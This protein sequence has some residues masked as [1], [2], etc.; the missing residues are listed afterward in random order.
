MASKFKKLF[1]AP[2]LL[3][4][5]SG[6]FIAACVTGLTIYW[7]VV[8]KLPAIE[9]LRD[10]Q[11]QVPLKIYTKDEKLIAEYGEKRRAPLEI[12]Q[13]PK[14]LINAVLSAED[15]RFY[16]H[17]GVDPKGLLRA[18][19]YLIR[20]GH[21][22]PGGS[23]ITM[24]VARNFFL[25]RE[26]TY[27]RKLNE[28]LLSF[29]IEQ[30]LSKDE[31]LELYLNKIYLGNR[32]YGF[33]AAAQVYY[34]KTLDEMTPA[35]IAM[36]AGLPKAPSAYNP[37]VNPERALKRRNYVLSRMNDLGFLSDEDYETARNSVDDAELHGLRVEVEAPYLAEMVRAEL[38]DR[39]GEDTYTQGYKV[40]TTVESRTQIAANEA[41]RKN[42]IAYEERHGFRGP[43]ANVDL[44][45]VEGFDEMAYRAILSDYRPVNKL[46]A[47]LVTAVNEKDIVV[48]QSRHGQIKIDWE[49]LKWARPW[50][51]DGKVPGEEPTKASDFLTTG[52]IIRIVKV[53]DGKEGEPDVWKLAQIP[54][55]EGA[56]VSLSA[57]DGAL[58]ALVGG[59]DYNKSKFNRV[60]QAERQPGSNIKP[61][62]Y[63]AA[64]EKGYTAASLINDA[65]IVFEDPGLESTW[66]PENYSGR[67][68]GPTRLRK[69][70]INS[71]NLVS[72]RLLRAIGI[73]YAINYLQKFGFRKESLPRDLSLSLGSAAIT[74]MELVTGYAAFANGGY[75]VEPYFI[76]RLE[77]A[78]NVVIMRS[79]PLVVCEQCE[80]DANNNAPQP[81]QDPM[82]TEASMT[83]EGELAENAIPENTDLLVP[84]YEEQLDPA[85][86]AESEIDTVNNAIP[87][88]VAKRIVSPQ[89]IYIMN[90][91]LRDVIKRGTGK[92]A[93]ALNRNDIAGKTGTTNDQQDAWFSG[94]NPDV[95]TTAWVGFDEPHTLGHNEY[96]GRAA[97][98]MWIE[99]MAEALKGLPEPA[100]ETPPG[101]VTVRIDPE[102]GLLVGADFPNA[103]FEIFRAEYVPKRLDEDPVV[104]DLGS[105]ET[106][107]VKETENI[108]E[109]LF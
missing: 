97:L 95:V 23:T 15:D 102:T 44:S 83:A 85:M 108:P 56:L 4:L 50:N 72:I 74:P 54:R 99:Y 90:S 26:R 100:L 30:E 6:C 94:F 13:T 5:A 71:R 104:V 91:I 80:A 16:E 78:E 36:I 40:Y 67:V 106:T 52:D 51:G 64:L 34:G 46:W 18:V 109:Q 20:T 55:V 70:L 10:V 81:G 37:I 76:E 89:N 60:T 8:P 65:P 24:Q 31:I 107:P 11:L 88:R 98:P 84:V 47:A 41:L 3:T 42:I 57:H 32:S 38:Y 92:R 82:L 7:F 61:F 75:K 68:F 87:Q 9:S 101:L 103:A 27:L 96:G 66:R 58:L 39:L 49:G 35:Q 59:F 1:S 29:K 2:V 86:M 69:A 22:G 12:E 43:E 93:L 48:Y 21:K 19:V 77:T 25:S 33:A 53:K 14:T 28:I 105:G 63:S 62:N 45:Q 79:N 73:S 17:Y